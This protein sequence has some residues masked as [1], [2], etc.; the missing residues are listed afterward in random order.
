MS[1]KKLIEVLGRGLR[2]RTGDGVVMLVASRMEQSPREVSRPL[3]A[4]VSAVFLVVAFFT[5][6]GTLIRSSNTRYEDL[7]AET[8]VIEASTDSIRR[9]ADV[10]E[11]RSDVEAFVVQHLVQATTADGAPIGPGVVADCESVTE[12]DVGIVDCSEGVFVS[13]GVTLSEGAPISI[14]SSDADTSV[15]FAGATFQGPYPAAVIVDPTVLPETFVTAISDTQVLVRPAASADLE[16]F[17]T[18]ILSE[19]PTAWVRSIAEV[20]REFSAPAREVRTLALIGLGLVMGI[21]ILNLSMGTVSHLLQRRN[22]FAFLRAGGLPPAEIRRL[23]ALETTM[24]LAVLAA[25]G[26]VLGLSAGAAVATSAGTEPRIP[27]LTVAGVFLGVVFLGVLV[28]G[29]FAPTVDRFTSPSG[30]RFE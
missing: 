24:L 16:S 21:A 27:W 29:A 2:R 18:S 4:V 11:G 25:T 20:E 26:T 14:R 30:L 7:S 15:P 3:V 19:A 12:M 9:I 23:V 13:S 17:R 10:L 8:I 6:T 5:I 22:A 1:T 28:W